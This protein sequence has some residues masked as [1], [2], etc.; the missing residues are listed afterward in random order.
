MKGL[1]LGKRACLL[2]LCLSLSACAVKTSYRFLDWIIAW[3]LDDYLALTNTQQIVFDQQLEQILTWHQKT[4]LTLYCDWLI[5]GQKLLQHPLVLDD[6][7]LWLDQSSQFWQ[8]LMTQL[9][10]A[11]AQVL[12]LLSDKQ[13]AVMMQKLHAK[14]ADDRDDYS[15]LYVQ[16][17]TQDRQE[18]NRR[19]GHKIRKQ[20]IRWL[21]ELSPEQQH[22]I[23]Q[24]FELRHDTQG[25]W[26]DN[27]EQWLN[28]FEVVMHERQ[29]PDFKTA[30]ASLFIHT[31]SRRTS[32]YQ[33]AL[34]D[35]TRSA[36]LLIIKLQASLDDQQINHL[37]NEIDTWVNVM[38]DLA[39]Q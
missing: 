24:W 16:G 19:Q 36:L 15:Q 12:V 7:S 30:L 13:V 39:D 3:Q 5:D 9:T 20:F 17:A 38:G 35:N 25:F 14:L 21:G 11:S 31:Q 33:K 34:E 37:N 4:Q 26:L 10:P 18:F 22:W 23:N 28:D 1:F 29:K 8:Q 2:L 32:V 27:R 6:L